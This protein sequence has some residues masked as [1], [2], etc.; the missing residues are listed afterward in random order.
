MAPVVLVTYAAQIAYVAILYLNYYIDIYPN[1]W[2]YSLTSAYTLPYAY[3]YLGAVNVVIGLW[4]LFTGMLTGT[5]CILDIFDPDLN[6]FKAQNNIMFSCITI[7]EPL[8]FFGNYYW[9]WKFN[10]N[11]FKFL[12]LSNKWAF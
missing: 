1:A 7:D 2:I 5:Y 4:F 3:Y 11:V 8:T 10:Q 9:T 6:T 12:N